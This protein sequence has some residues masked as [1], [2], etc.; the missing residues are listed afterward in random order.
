MNYTEKN[1]PEIETIFKLNKINKK[2]IHSNKTF[3]CV[4]SNLK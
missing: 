3:H 2:I 4:N 1:H